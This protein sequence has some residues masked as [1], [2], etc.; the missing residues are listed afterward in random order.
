MTDTAIVVT[1]YNRPDALKRT[2]ESLRKLGLPILVVDDASPNSLG[3]FYTCH[4]GGAFL[5]R[6]PENRGLAGALN[7]GLSYWLADPMIKWISYFQDDVDVDPDILEVLRDVQH[8][9]DR[10]LLTGHDAVEHPALAEKVVSGVKVKLKKSCRATHMHAHRSYWESV[11]PIP[12]RELGA[13]KPIPGKPRGMGSNVDWWVATN[14]P[15]SVGATGRY[16]TCVP[17]LVRTFL[18]KK[19]ESTWDN[20]LK[21]EEPPL[22]REAIKG[23]VRT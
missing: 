12:S 7:I 13:P 8:E 4:D 18:W 14:A 10:P 15:K 23:W 19:A 2:L 3:T 17:G 21:A 16:V 9:K 22:S 5:L 1:T 20:G 11:M 6:L